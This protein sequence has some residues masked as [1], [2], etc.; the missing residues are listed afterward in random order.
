MKYFKTD[1]IRGI[2]NKDLSFDLII[3]LASSLKCLGRNVIISCDTRESST[4]IKSLMIGTLLASN[5]NVYDL[6]VVSTPALIYLCYL[7]GFVGVMVSASHNPYY[8]N[9]IKIIN[10]GF[11]L[12]LEE[13][14]LIES[15]MD[16]NSF[17]YESLGLFKD[18]SNEI[19]LY[20]NFID[21]FKMKTNLKIALDLANGANFKIAH[22]IFK[23]VSPSVL[24]LN[25][26]PN[27]KNINDKCGSTNPNYLSEF[28]LKNHYDIGF[29]FDGDGDRVIAVGPDGKIYDGNMLIYLIAKYLKGLHKL[30][31]NTVVLS[32]TSNL[33]LI[34]S[35]KKLNINVVETDVGDK[36][37][38]HEIFKNCYSLGGEA[39]GHIIVPSLFHTGD[40]ILNALYILN[41]LES[42]HTNLSDWFSDL[43][44]Y[45]LVSFNLHVLNKDKILNDRMLKAEIESIKS[46][47]MDSKI[48]LRKSGTEDLIRVFISG[49]DEETLKYY[50][51]R[52][53][54]LIEELDKNEIE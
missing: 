14:L 29:A 52:I 30:N 9:G 15:I 42:S 12:S 27:G 45:P 36:Y 11:K 37:V 54:N 47:L 53:K 8:D 19:N 25:D 17:S 16:K 7:K 43:E 22:N 13:E 51:N 35:L 38:M 20:F 48:I 3:R 26:K 2:P 1:G 46:N 4:F 21:K 31:K 5:M 6:G 33:G 44:L 34:H 10:K 32:K 23:D 49:K 18:I 41:I 40:G 50:G 28:I 39:S 24:F